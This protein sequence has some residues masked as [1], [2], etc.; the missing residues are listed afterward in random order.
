M[1]E[2]TFPPNHLSTDP[3][4]SLDDPQLR[5]GKTPIIRDDLSW[6]E[7]RESEKREEFRSYFN[8]TYSLF[9]ALHTTF[10]TP[11]AFF[12]KWEP[13]RHPPIFYLS[14]T[15]SF[16]VNK[17]KLGGFIS[18]RLDPVLEIQTAVGVDEMEWDDLDTR[19]YIWPDEDQ[20][21][22]EPALASDFLDKVIEYRRRV[23]SL[24]NRMIDEQPLSW[25]VTPDSFWWIL[26]M[27]T[28]HERIH[29]ETSSVIFRQADLS[30]MRPSSL[31][32]PCDQGRFDPSP[33][34]EVR[35]GTPENGLIAVPEGEVRLGRALEG[36]TTWGW[37]NEFGTEQRRIVAAFQASRH[38]VT[39]AEF[40]EFVEEGGY[41]EKQWWSEEGWS[42]C[43]LAWDRQ[44]LDGFRQLISNPGQQGDGN[45]WQYPRFWV[46]REEGWFLRTQ[47]E[48][49]PMPW[50]WPVEVNHHEA[51]AY[52]RWHSEKSGKRL[53]LPSEEEFYRLRDAIQNDY[54]TTHRAPAWEQAPGN[55]NLEHWASPCPVGQF[56]AENGFSDV[57][58]NVWQHSASPTDVLPGFKPHPVYEDFTTPTVDGMHSMIHG[59]SWISTGGAGATRECRYGFRRHFY[60]H[61]GFRYVASDIEIS[62]EVVPYE[63][64]PELCNALRFHFGDGALAGFNYPQRLATLVLDAVQQQLQKPIESL[65]VLVLGCG[66]GRAAIELAKA[67][68]GDVHAADRTASMFNLVSRYLLGEAGRMHWSNYLEG[69]LVEYTERSRDDLEINQALPISWHQ[70]PDFGSIDP[71]KFADFDLLL[72]AN[73]GTLAQLK[74]PGEVLRNLYHCVR[75][76]GLLVLGT[77]YQWAS[78]T[79]Q[80]GYAALSERLEAA[81]EPVLEPIDLEYAI[82]ETARK[83]NCGRQQISFWVRREQIV[84]PDAAITGQRNETA[85]AGQ[86]VYEEKSTLDQYLDFHFGS[87][88]EIENYPQRCAERCIA[89]CD[90]LGID[91]GSALEVGG[92]PGR[93]ALELSRSFAQVDGGDYSQRFVAVMDQ[94]LEQ[95]EISWR[96]DRFS[97]AEQGLEPV[98]RLRYRVV[99][100]H[101][102]PEEY[103]DY[104][105]ICGFNL[106]DRL[107]NPAAALTQMK[108]RLRPGGLLVLS[109]PYTWLEE[110]TAKEHWLG[111]YKYGDNDGPLTT[112]GL[113]DWM[114]REGFEVVVP[115]E[116]CWFTLMEQP[117]GRRYQRTR[118]EISFFRL[119]M[120]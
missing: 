118:A 62:S 40:F 115:P 17:L 104:D 97:L 69:D 95:G 63:Q 14:H 37:D 88:E 4:C 23:R 98:G 112:I 36:T 110:F 1:A 116:D 82:Q 60:Q 87:S 61:A 79:P 12:R 117:D 46:E 120:E 74:A 2:Q 32:P 38:L 34:S 44:G 7:L 65:S 6:D 16:F 84:G 89:L 72:L 51:A 78:T 30:V 106:I 18:L 27:G 29:L 43:A 49:V 85:P 71:N 35:K 64:N 70:V 45:G 9:E 111:G 67:G 15:A 90:Q 80:G 50:D 55:L 114:V 48:E 119:A 68:V 39:N 3:D 75:P 13:L 54:Q 57:V 20:V 113:R 25:P 56:V 100:A 53:R 73:P 66:P 103:N 21:D 22:R 101:N 96:G 47:C 93:A 59:G 8:R 52:C 41:R 10:S 77:T 81:W 102:L 83:N 105:L 76:G 109:S 24:L 42:W 58:G 26:L 19:N 91:K 28:E 5:S 99:D 33:D 11:T 94:L 92:G 31:F 108:H 86:D 107:S